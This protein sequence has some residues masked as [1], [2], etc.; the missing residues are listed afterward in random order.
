MKKGI[1][2]W[3]QR[4]MEN[5]RLLGLLGLCCLVLFA[6]YLLNQRMFL[7]SADQQLQYN[8]FYGEWLEMIERMLN[9]HQ[10][11]FYSWNTFLGNNFY[12]AKAYY[13]T[14]DIFLPVI[15]LF[16]N[17]YTEILMIISVF[18]VLFSGLTFASFLKEF[19]FQ[20]R[21]AID[22]ISIMYALGGT[23]AIF[24]GQYMFQR[25]YAFFPL[26][27]WGTERYLNRGKLCGFAL[28]VTL[29][30]LSSY[31]LM[32]PSSLFL[33]LYF[34]FSCTRR[35]GKLQ[36]LPFLR[37][38]LPLI[39]AYFV[40]L[41][42]SGV[43]SVPAILYT[44]GNSRLGDYN[45]WGNLW[46]LKV[47]IGFIF[48]YVT[49]PFNLYTTIPYM[50]IS[51][52]NG[53]DYWYSIYSSVLGCLLLFSFVCRKGVKDKK[54]WLIPY[55]ILMVFTMVKPLNSIVHGFSQPSFRWMFLVV[56]F[57][58][59]LAAKTL[60]EM[61]ESHLFAGYRL[62]LIIYVIAFLTGVFYQIVDFSLYREHI[63]VSLAFLSCGLL[64]C[65]LWKRGMMK[66]LVL[67]LCTELTLSMGMTLWNLSKDYHPYRPS[68]D[69]NLVQYEQDMDED[70]M[71]RIYIDSETMM[72][73]SSMNKNQSLPLGY[74]S[75]ATYDSTYEPSLTPFLRDNHFNWHNIQIEDPDLLKLLGVKYL[76]VREENELPQNLDLEYVKDINE[77]HIYRLSDYNHIGFTYN[78]LVA[79]SEIN[80][81]GLS[82][83][84]WDE[85][86]S[87][88]LDQWEWCEILIVPDEVLSRIGKLPA[89][90]RQQL[91]VQE[92]YANGLLG[93]VEND[94]ETILF[95]SIPYSS[96]WTAFDNG[97]KIPVIQVNKGF[98]GLYLEPGSHT[99]QLSFTPPGWKAGAFMTAAGILLWSGLWLIERKKR[100]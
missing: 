58:L 83:W 36:L 85:N 57:G 67:L 51:G 18:L 69:V 70:R 61:Q 5:R 28:V 84:D 40:G 68:L 82:D 11:P 79:E 96:G 92:R 34:F 89:M 60:E 44:L 75:V 52:F 62:F 8:F 47:W 24:T 1:F 54:I 76:Y 10:F 48:S 49:P 72:P 6:P 9:T 46:E 20:K 17:H 27:L 100:K 64:Y 97:K 78:Q 55:G 7:F 98:I 16:R 41:M 38:S 32:F 31:Y 93:T 74:M 42:I 39:G 13:V 2:N 29:L 91:I 21:L 80:P 45:T 43:I 22:C 81:Q 90:E 66:Q 33:V 53:H 94:E 71:F 86:L 37:R 19:G 88:K 15:Y 12:A 73:I 65:W 35:T 56:T 87:Q 50:F 63:V 14:G 4:W 26:L 95:I 23:A 30:F 59:L 3:R 25:F 77:Y 99:I